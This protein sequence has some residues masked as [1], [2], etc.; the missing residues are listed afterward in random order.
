MQDAKERAMQSTNE[1]YTNVD[2]IPQAKQTGNTKNTQKLTLAR[3]LP[4]LHS[5]TLTQ[6]SKSHPDLI[7]N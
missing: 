6:T 4:S 7:L 2:K 5:Q 3:T 1:V